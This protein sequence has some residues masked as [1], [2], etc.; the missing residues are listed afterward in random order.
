MSSADP[1][2]NIILHG[3]MPVGC[4]DTS[5]SVC[6]ATGAM[7]DLSCFRCTLDFVLNI[8]VLLLSCI[9]T[10]VMTVCHIMMTMIIII[11]EASGNQ[12]PEHR[13]QATNH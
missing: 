8:L 7:S 4:A 9:A 3:S 13:D 11:I 1:I 12:R 5:S 2:N 10:M 6:G